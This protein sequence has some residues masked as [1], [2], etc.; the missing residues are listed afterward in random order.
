MRIEYLYDETDD[1]I[2]RYPATMPHVQRDQGHY[3][4]DELVGLV[5]R[6]AV[7]VLA[8]A[9]GIAGE[10]VARATALRD[11]A[12]ALW[13]GGVVGGWLDDDGREKLNDILFDAESLDSISIEWNGD[14]GTV[15]VSLAAGWRECPDNEERNA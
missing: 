8:A 12:A 4:A 15:T 7:D 3:P 11:E 13:P 2:L 6:D 1:G 14:A 5:L 9:D 10:T